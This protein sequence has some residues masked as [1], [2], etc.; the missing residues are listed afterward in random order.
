MKEEKTRT[1]GRPEKPI[2]EEQFA[3]VCEEWKDGE[4]TARRAMYKL[5]MS[6]STFYRRAIARGYY[7]PQRR[8]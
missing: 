2:N 1:P 8:P 7:T 5:S 4:I 6:K 3:S